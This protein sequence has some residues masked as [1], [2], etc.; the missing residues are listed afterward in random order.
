MWLPLVILAVPTIIAGFW[1][2]NSGFADFVT[3][4]AIEYVNPFTENLTYI[5]VGVAVVGIALSW[6]IYGLGVLPVKIFTGNPIGGFIYR[7]LLN[8]YYID[9]LYGLI[10]RYIVF[11]L[12]NF[13]ALFDRY[14][15]DGSS[16]APPLWCAELAEST[17]RSETG[18]LQ[19][20]GA[21]LFGGVLVL[22]I[23]VFLAVSVL[24]LGEE[25]KE[26]TYVPTADVHRLRR[27]S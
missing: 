15:I 2:I 17:S 23:A 16:T 18:L 6:L 26:N 1:S 20:Y 9:E 25:G 7:V 14:V 12:A 19:N 4:N 27:P 8:K 13:A 22:L 24:Q 5:G 11:G 10:I 21:S 3:G